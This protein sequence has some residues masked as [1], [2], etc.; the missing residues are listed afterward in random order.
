MNLGFLIRRDVLPFPKVWRC[1]LEVISRRNCYRRDPLFQ[2]FDVCFPRLGLLNLSIVRMPGED[3]LHHSRVDSQSATSYSRKSSNVSGLGNVR[4]QG[5]PERDSATKF[6]LTA[7]SSMGQWKGGKAT[8][9]GLTMIDTLI[10]LL[11]IATIALC[12][13]RTRK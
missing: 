2:H 1:F 10:A 12:W 7:I 4:G 8:N 6:S 5:I 3:S 11:M 9:Q 13:V